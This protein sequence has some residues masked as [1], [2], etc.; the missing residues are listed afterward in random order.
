MSS[1]AGKTEKLLIFLGQQDP[2]VKPE[3][4]RKL[5]DST[6]RKLQECWQARKYEPMKPL[7]M[8]DLFNQHTAQLSGM[9]AN[10][11]INRIE[12]LK[13]EYIDL[14]NV[15]YTEKPD[16]R[17]F[18]ALITASAQDYYVDDPTGKFLR[19]DKAPARFQEFWTFHRVG[20]QWLLREIEQSGESDMLKEANFAEMLTD[21]TLKGIYGEVGKEKGGGRT[22]AGEGNRGEGNTHRAHAE[23]SR[24]DRQT[25]GS[26]PDARKGAAG[27][28]EAFISPENRGISTRCRHPISFRRLQRIFRNQIQT[29]AI[30][31]AEGR[32]SQSLRPKGGVDPGAEFRR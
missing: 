15:R 21:D 7:M 6:F 9:I 31:R 19:G 24:P 4:L 11:E 12:N 23:L 10:H 30:G 2:S 27:L 18:T 14:V 20:D 13:V 8:P 22:L 26:K 32:I 28:Y 29:M 3:G 5:V 16:Q 17:E 1:K 25:L